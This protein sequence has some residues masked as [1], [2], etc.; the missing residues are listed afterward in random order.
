MTIEEKVKQNPEALLVLVN[1]KKEDFRFAFKSLSQTLD[2]II[3]AIMNEYASKE[4]VEFNL[5]D[6]KNYKELNKLIEKKLDQ[7]M[8]EFLIE[9]N[10][11]P[12]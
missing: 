7:M 2:N 9:N 4:N 6:V 1:N 10:K 11:I 12:A 3:G 5:N 8:K